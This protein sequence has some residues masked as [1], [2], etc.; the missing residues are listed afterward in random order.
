MS[1]IA[2]KHTYDTAASSSPVVVNGAKV[3]LQLKPEGT[4][5]GTFGVSAMVVGA[6]VA[7]LDGPFRWRIEATDETGRLEWMWVRS[8]RTRTE[9]TKRDEPYPT[10]HLNH[11]A[12]FLKPKRAP[13]PA[14]AV[15]DIPGLLQVKPRE[16]GALTIDAKIT[17]A[18][19][20]TSETRVVRFRLSPAQRRAD[21]FVFIPTEIVKGLRET[22]EDWKDHGWD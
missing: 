11:R 22:P 6:T 5:K 9:V 15:F 17:V 3:R 13:G 8:L 7:T 18:G 21:E 16:D 4:G 14:R 20:G 2:K 19:H 10:A 12:D 1:L